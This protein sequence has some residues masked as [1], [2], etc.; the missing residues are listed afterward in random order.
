MISQAAVLQI[1][2]CKC[3]HFPLIMMLDWTVIVQVYHF[4]DKLLYLKEN[5]LTEKYKSN[6]FFIHNIIF[7]NV[8]NFKWLNQQR[9]LDI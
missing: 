6:N 7:I 4:S 1:Q 5:L 8:N 3:N 2:A 9:S